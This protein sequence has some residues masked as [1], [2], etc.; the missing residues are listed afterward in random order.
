M[1]A[2][3]YRAV[4]ARGQRLRGREEASTVREL[5]AILESRGLLVVEAAETAAGAAGNGFGQRR[6]V[7]ETTR[8]LASLLAAGLPLARALEVA[9]GLA[10]GAVAR[11]LAAVRSRVRRGDPLHTA[12]ADHPGLF[13]PLYVGV[14]RAGERSGDLAGAFRRLEAQLDRE[15]ALRSKLVSASIYPLI[16]A[17]VGG[18]AVVMLTLFVLPRFAELLQDAGA[19]LPGIGNPTALSAAFGTMGRVGP[20]GQ[21]W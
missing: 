19:P 10:P 20:L 13:P 9:E 8:A 2:F 14:I 1:P 4:D 7:L 6:A 18:V 17:V 16:L 3:A 5:T 15:E 11:S 21:A 12:L